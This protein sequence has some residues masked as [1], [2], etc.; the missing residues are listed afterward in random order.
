MK[1]YS[2]W[3]EITGRIFVLD[4]E[5]EDRLREKYPAYA[6]RCKDEKE[7]ARDICT[8]DEEKETFAEL[9]REKLSDQFPTDD[10]LKLNEI[11]FDLS[12]YR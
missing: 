12:T 8:P 1:T 10:P 11:I 2:C 6:E 5:L 4:W 3:A 7:R 9:A